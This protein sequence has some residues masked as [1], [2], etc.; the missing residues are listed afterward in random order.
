MP[1]WDNLK[2]RFVK[3]D[4]VAV[5]DLGVPAT[6]TAS[7]NT[8]WFNAEDIRQA[9]VDVTIAGATARRRASRSPSRRPTR[10][11]QHRTVATFAAHHRSRGCSSQDRGRPR[12]AV[13]DQV[14]RD[15]HD[16][17]L[18]GRGREGEH[19]VDGLAGDPHPELEEVVEIERRHGRKPSRR[20]LGYRQRRPDARADRQGVDH[21]SG[22]LGR[23]GG[24]LAAERADRPGRAVGARGLLPRAGEPD[25]VLRAAQHGHRPRRHGHDRDADRDEGAGHGRLRAPAVLAAD[26]GAPALVGGDYKT[27]AVQKTFGPR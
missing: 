22:R 18:H 16:A 10:R 24:R 21:G 17:E 13:A 25:E 14:G 12:R 2:K 8:A 23:V 3:G 7:G 26:W 27:T 15:G 20:D 5:A 4:D 11:R 1:R 9:I 19:E 6:I